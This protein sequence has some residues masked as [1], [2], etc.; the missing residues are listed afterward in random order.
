MDNQSVEKCAQS[1]WREGVDVK[2]WIKL[3]VEKC[4]ES[5]CIGEREMSQVWIIGW[6]I[7]DW[8]SVMGRVWRSVIWMQQRRCGADGSEMSGGGGKDFPTEL[9]HNESASG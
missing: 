1:H 4:A 7:R 6:R 2:V 5:H 3:S 9:L 8:R